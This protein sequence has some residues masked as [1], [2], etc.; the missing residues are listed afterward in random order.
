[1]T[2]SATERNGSLARIFIHRESMQMKISQAALV[3]GA[4]L[5]FAATTAPAS[6]AIVTYDWTTTSTA[7]VAN[8][9]MAIG[10]GTITVDTSQT[11]LVTSAT[12]PSVH[13]VG[14]LIT[15]I[16]GSIGSVT[17]SGLAPV[18]ADPAHNE[19]NDNLLFV[20]GSPEV[21]DTHGFA[22]T[23]AAGAFPYSIFSSLA[24]GSTTPPG[25]NPF[26]E[27]GPGGQFLSLGV[28]TFAITPVPLPSSAWMLIL[29]LGGLGFAALRSARGSKSGSIG[30]AA[31]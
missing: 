27:V 15:G 26:Q 31:A 3:L 18:N 30:L 9:G 12:N 8:G 10:S 21:L 24:L 28:G 16:T 11:T 17:I 1:M 7:T 2:A 6:A 13:Y 22:F 5:S 20:S 14:D 19:T 23:S 4:L 29:G 25:P